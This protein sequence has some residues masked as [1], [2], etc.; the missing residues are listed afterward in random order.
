M[1]ALDHGFNVVIEKPI[2]L[3][4]DEARQLQQKAAENGLILALHT[5]TPA[6][7]WSNKPDKW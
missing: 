2:A 3:S 6:T 5:L 7:L 4:L 1:M